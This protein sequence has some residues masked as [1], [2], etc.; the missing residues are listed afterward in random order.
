[1]LTVVKVELEYTGFTAAGG[2]A[3]IV[4]APLEAVNEETPPLPIPVPVPVPVPTPLPA[5]IPVPV[6][7][8]VLVPVDGASDWIVIRGV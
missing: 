5:S 2:A 7:V 1:M 6:P 4:E 8:P 3:V